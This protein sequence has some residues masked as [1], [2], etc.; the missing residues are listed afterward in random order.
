MRVTHTAELTGAAAMHAVRALRDPEAGDPPSITGDAQAQVAP[1]GWREG[2]EQ[3]LAAMEQ[4]TAPF[5][6]ARGGAKCR[7]ATRIGD[8]EDERV[9]ALY[10]VRR[11]DAGSELDDVKM[12]RLRARFRDGL[13][14]YINGREVVRRDLDADAEPTAFARRA[15]GPEWETFYIP[16]VPELLHEGSNVLAVEVRPSSRRAAPALELELTGG[17]APRLVRGPMVQKVTRDSAVIVF[18]TDLPAAGSVDYGAT[19]ELG[20]SATSAGGA[21]AVHH[22][23]ELTGLPAGKQ[24]H[25]RVRGG[26]DTSETF[27]FALAPADGE[28]VRLAIY[29]DVRGGHDTHREIAASMLLDAPDM[30]L[31]TGDLVL[32]GSDEGDWQRFFEVTRELLARVPYYPAVGNHDLGRSGDERRRLNEIFAL[33]PGPDNRPEWGHWYSFT[34]AG[35]HFVMLDSN[36]YTHEEQREWLEADLSA[37]REAGVRAIFALTHNGPY[38]RGIHRG[39]A[40]ARKNYVPILEKHDVTLLFSGHD[41][42]YQRGEVGG[43]PYVVTGGGG[44]SLYGIR[45]GVEGRRRCKVDDG[46]QHVTRAHHYLLVTVYKSYVKLCPKRP[47]RTPLEKCVKYDLG[48]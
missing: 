46:A 19:A 5:G 25:Y 8:T 47:D 33:W 31:V 38:S 10:V 12:L 7:C 37:A 2:T 42:I 16:V 11:F 44:A 18:D 23:V 26:G 3:A 39:S 45:C 15:R 17:T 1:A 30:V 48:D 40:Y 20:E 14:V 27:A 21:L 24:V 9:A 32:R 41:H 6:G 43:L 22:V 29:G 34:V 4:G 35:L 13:V 36:A 28:V